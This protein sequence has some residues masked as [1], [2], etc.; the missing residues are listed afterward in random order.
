MDIRSARVPELQSLALLAFL[1]VPSAKSEELLCAHCMRNAW[2]APGD[3]KS[4]RQYAPSREIDIKHLIPRCHPRLQS[5]L[6]RRHGH[7]ALVAHRQ[8]PFPASTRCG[9]PA[10][11]VGHLQRAHPSLAIDRYPD[12]DHLLE[13]LSPVDKAAEV[14]IRYSASPRRGLYFRT[15]AEGYPAADS[16]LWTQGEPTEARHWFPS[17][18]APNEKFTSEVICHVPSDM[19]ALSNGKQ[20]SSEL[21]A[22]TGLR[23]FRWLQ[24]KPHVNYLIALAAGHLKG[25]E[26]K[27]R[28]IP[29]ALYT[30]ASQIANARN[31]LAG[32]SDMMAFFEKEIGVAYPWDKYYQVAVADYHWG[33]MENTTLTIL[34]DATLYPDG[35]ETLR[36]SESLVAHELAHQWFGDLGD[37]QRLEP[38]VA[39]R[40][41]CHLLR[42]VVSRQQTR[43]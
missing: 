5:Q 26:E 18:D 27:Y 40:G 9:R 38:S 11:A 17:F 43:T 19:V 15:P 1:T 36:S 39:Q 25:I 3:G 2:L 4:T 33:G 20:M 13:S 12:R 23:S 34:N 14:V 42:R 37:L 24:D 31:T 30:P 8:T 7:A 35:F 29:L 41:I 22:N 32:T 10:G 21:D 6:D 16:H 28:D